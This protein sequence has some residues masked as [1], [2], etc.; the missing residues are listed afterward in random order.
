ML[1][2]TQYIHASGLTEQ[3]FARQIGVSLNTINLVVCER[4]GVSPQLAWKLAARFP[5]RPAAFWLRLQADYDAWFF[6]PR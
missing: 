4:R 5:E 2:R 6:G 3:N 1:L